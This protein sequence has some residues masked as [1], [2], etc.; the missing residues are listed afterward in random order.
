VDAVRRWT[1][2]STPPPSGALKRLDLL[3]PLY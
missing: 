1:A 2:T 3:W